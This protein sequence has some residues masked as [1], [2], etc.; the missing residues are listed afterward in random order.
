MPTQSLSP[1]PVRA[2]LKRELSAYFTNPTAYI[3]ITLF[4]LLS[5]VAAFWVEAFFTRNLANLDQLNRWF[6][7]LL[8]FLI[9]AIT[10]STWAEE[11]KQGTEELL[12]TLPAPEWKLALG[13]YLGC[14]A[15]YAV[16]LVFAASHIVVLAYLGRPDVGLLLATYVGYLLAGAALIGLG[17]FA[18][19]LSAS[20]TIAYIA[21]AV[22]C[23]VMV[24]LF[25][26]EPVL[27]ASI[28]PVLKGLSIP[29]RMES[30]GRGVID[31][32]D[33]AYFVAVAAIGVLLTAGVLRRRRAVGLPQ[34]GALVHGAVRLVAL[35][36][37]G[38]CAVLFLDRSG[39]RADATA[40]RLW[41]LS[42]ATRALVSEIPSTDHLT[43]TAF[44][45]PRTPASLVQQ[46]ETLEG[47]MR[48]LAA[49][50]RGRITARTL[51]TEPN[52][53]AARDAERAWG[54]K[55]RSVP[56]E[57]GSVGNMQETY[58]SVVVESAAG[59]VATIPFLSRGLP[60]EY[61]LARAIRTLAPGKRKTVGI[62][63]TGAGL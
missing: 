19:S 30:F 59:E 61:E 62:L 18:S 44:V 14:L 3:F 47:L 56:A 24:A 36:L 8:L 22:A 21:G 9:P 34:G 51:V 29:A 46:R 7:V 13:K 49:T 50:S 60:A 55:P 33:T 31:P 35:V 63:E 5:G 58:L 6:P 11:R 42:P 32:A 25:L 38:A 2:L 45:S 17:L 39:V 48:E 54:V 52:T 40:E 28:G 26:L 10:M 53:E 43:V 16:C 4:V 57:D 15:I 37:I 20:A 12:L 41:T 23:G 1:R 27:P